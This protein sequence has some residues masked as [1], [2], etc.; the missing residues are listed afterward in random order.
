MVSC[1][2]NNQP[3]PCDIFWAQYGWFLIVPFLLIGL[4][5]TLKPD[6]IIKAQI[7]QM[8]LMGGKWIPGKIIP[9]IYMGMGIV[10]L[11]CDIFFLYLMFSQ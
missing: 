5:L 8:K 3:I 10:F 4:L 1:Y 11:L 2:V 9:K 6:W 7:W